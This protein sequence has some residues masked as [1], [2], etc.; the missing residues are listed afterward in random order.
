L[1]RRPRRGRPHAAHRLSEEQPLLKS[2]IAAGAPGIPAATFD[3]KYL[4]PLIQQ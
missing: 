3:G 2:R 4:I 1:A